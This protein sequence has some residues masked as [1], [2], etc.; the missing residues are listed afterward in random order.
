MN[1]LR[2]RNLLAAAASGIALAGA[3][4]LAP[5]GADT[6]ATFTLSSAGGLSISEPAGTTTTPANLGSTATGVKPWTTGALG[7]VAVTDTRTGLLL[8]TWSASVTVSDFALQNPPTGA[9]VEQKTVPA[10]GM[11]YNMGTPTPGSENPVGA[12]FLATGTAVVAGTPLV[13]GT[14]SAAGVNSESWSPTLT[15]ALTNQLP[16][17]YQGT[18]VHSAL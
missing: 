5:A 16:G 9:T 2:T 7:T 18:I 12:A 11:I 10:T 4:S 15:V 17:T 13:V 1:I 14:M 6:T 3:L 8:N